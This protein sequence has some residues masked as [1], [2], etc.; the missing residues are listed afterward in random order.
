MLNAF[1]ILFKPPAENMKIKFKDKFHKR[2][3]FKLENNT[4][5]KITEYNWEI[6][7]NL[8]EN[9]GVSN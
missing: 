7:E 1:E 4:E 9:D 3:K 2:W 8:R 6:F 5:V